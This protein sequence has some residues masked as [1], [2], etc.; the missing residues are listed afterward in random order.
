MSALQTDIITRLRPRTVGEI[1][2]GAFRLYRRNFRTFLLIVAVVYL[3]VRL[4]SYG[5][6]VFLLGRYTPPDFSTSLSGSLVA[7]NLVSQIDTLKTYLETFLDYFAQWALTLAV[8]AAVLDRTISFGEAY[9][10]VRRRFWAVV[11][12]MGLQAL[13]ALGFFLPVL[14]TIMA[15][16]V[17]GTGT[18]T[19]ISVIAGCLS[20]FPLIYAIIQIRLQVI[21]PAAANEN[22]SPREALRR[23]W[24]LTRNYWWRT[25]ALGLVLGILNSIVSLG[26]GAVLVGLAGILFK[27]D[28]YTSLAVTQGIGI[29]TTIIYVPIEIGAIALYYFDQRVRK[30]GFDLDTAIAGRYEGDAAQDG[31]WDSVSR[32]DYTI[33]NDGPPSAPPPLGMEASMSPGS[34]EPIAAHGVRQ[35]S[36]IPARPSA[37]Q[38][39]DAMSAVRHRAA[40]DAEAHRNMHWVSTHPIKRKT[41]RHP[42]VYDDRDTGD[43]DTDS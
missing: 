16:V 23:S 36:D 10:E 8:T 9:S 12:L 2:D 7:S 18:A 38:S 35:D 29:L 30:E 22:L 1:I 27:F 17:G 40:R 32:Y 33:E 3:P 5:A 39:G 43:R 42:G 26:P 31:W 15:A 20:I 21:L 4:L 19:S 13:I 28:I 14:L 24:E 6:D 41:D 37:R 11:G 34:D 25:L